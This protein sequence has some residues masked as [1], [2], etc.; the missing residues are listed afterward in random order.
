MTRLHI[1]IKDSDRAIIVINLLKE[2]PFVEFVEIKESK[3]VKSARKGN[4]SLEDLFGL[5][6][7]RE[8]SLINIRKKA[9]DRN[10]DT[11]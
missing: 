3:S 8:V 1:N 5:W 6:E 4:K 9:W 7:N 10:N 2:L 11:L